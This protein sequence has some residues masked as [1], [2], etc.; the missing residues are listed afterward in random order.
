MPASLASSPPAL[1]PSALA[2]RR[3]QSRST[4]SSGGTGSYR[5]SLGGKSIGPK[6]Q[7]LTSGSLR[8][9]PS[10]GQPGSSSY[11]E[12]GSRVSFGSEVGSD[13]GLRFGSFSATR[14][15]LRDG[16]SRFRSSFSHR[17]AH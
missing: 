11:A 10:T 14:E 6:Y 4:S 2:R 8:R 13:G 16:K 7:A 17:A 3:S 5:S 15:E 12:E 1:P 9:D